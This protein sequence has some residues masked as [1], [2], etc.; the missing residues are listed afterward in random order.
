MASRTTLVLLL[1]GCVL[2]YIGANPAL[3]DMGCSW[4]E[5]VLAWVLASVRGRGK[6]KR[7][8]GVSG[9]LKG[10]ESSGEKGT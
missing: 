2:K 3:E 7:I 4:R 9:Y 5:R 10:I 6:E 8:E 1:F